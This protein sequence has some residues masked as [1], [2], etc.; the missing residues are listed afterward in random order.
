MADPALLES[1][2]SQEQTY[3]CIVTHSTSPCLTLPWTLQEDHTIPT[4]RDQK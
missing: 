3:Q 4:G 2:Y 1:S